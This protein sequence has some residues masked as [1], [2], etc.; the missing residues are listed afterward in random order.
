VNSEILALAD[1]S[2][3]DLQAWRYLSDHAVEPNPFFDPDFVLASAAAFEERDEVGL[4]LVKDGADWSG[5]LPVRRNRRWHRIPLASIATWRHIY[6][7]LG[8]PLIMPGVE[9]ETLAS[10]IATLRRLA[11]SYFSALEWIPGE[12]TVYEALAAVLPSRSLVF[13][14][15]QRA[16]LERRAQDDYL[17]GWVKSKDRREFRRR[18]R[19]LGE[20]L[21]GAPTLANR[22]D[23]STAIDDFLA[24]ETAGWKGEAGTALA[25]N[26]AHARFFREVTR[27]FAERGALNLIFLDA[28]GTEVAATCDLVAGGVDF[29]FKVAYDERFSRFAPGRD[30]AFKMID[31][32]HADQSLRL[33]DSCTAPDNDLYNRMWRDRRRLLTLTI[34][35]EGPGGLVAMPAI[36]LGMALRERRRGGAS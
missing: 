18:S 17:E 16:T 34:G 1:L 27:A 21:G 3:H 20:E 10:M 22:S 5:C 28:G 25:S 6:C 2:E 14:D 33:M 36:R 31:F 19:L 23:D 29:C 24:M 11:G 13:E 7:F 15:F 12:G 4:L 26:P 9:G 30:L 32:F 35:S 8:T